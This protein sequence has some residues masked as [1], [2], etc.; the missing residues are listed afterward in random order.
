MKKTVS[1]YSPAFAPKRA[2]A[3]SQNSVADILPL[4]LG[5][6]RGAPKKPNDDAFAPPPHYRAPHNMPPEKS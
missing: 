3:A 5:G 6:G 2:E 1:P 4:L